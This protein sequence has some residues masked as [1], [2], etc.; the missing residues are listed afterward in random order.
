M[1]SEKVSIA[2]GNDDRI[3]GIISGPGR[4]RD[5][6]QTGLIFAH[7]AANDMN[8]PLMVFVAEE[9]AKAGYVTLRFN[10]PYKEKGKNT[11]DPQATLIRTWQSVYGYMKNK[12]PYEIEEIIAVGKSMGGRIASQ[13]VAD[14]LM[15]VAKLIFLGYPLH[16]PG[17][18]DQLRD[19]HLYEIK[20]P[21]L[22][23]A[24]TRDP[25]CDISLLKGVLDKLS[26]K[27]D[28]ELIEKGDHSF[29]LPKAESRFQTDVYRQVIE[30]CLDWI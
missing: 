28:L 29:N 30:K 12:T 25:F 6:R 9:L 8:H 4:L 1:N 13:M 21:M 19:T 14:D 11:P 5:S 10:F 7:G 15:D 26:C 27:W 22:F 17:K 3:S 24:G 2:S 20:A 23:F 18:K 16:A